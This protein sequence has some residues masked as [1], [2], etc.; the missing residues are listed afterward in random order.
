MAWV[1]DPENQMGC[2]NVLRI[3]TDKSYFPSVRML[4]VVYS[5]IINHILIKILVLVDVVCLLSQ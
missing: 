1:G 2:V 3:R 5:N 4:Q